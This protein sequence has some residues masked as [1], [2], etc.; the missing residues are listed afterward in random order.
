[1]EVPTPVL[2]PAL[3]ALREQRSPDLT[4]EAVSDCQAFVQELELHF[5]VGRLVVCQDSVKEIR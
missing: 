1:M 5:E 4:P 3:F 2:Q